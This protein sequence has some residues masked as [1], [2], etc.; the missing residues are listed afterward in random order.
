M[1]YFKQCL[2]FDRQLTKL[3][4]MYQISK[5]LIFLQI[6]FDYKKNAF[7]VFLFGQKLR[8]R[9]GNKLTQSPK[10]TL[11]SK[12]K[13]SVLRR[14]YALKITFFFTRYGKQQ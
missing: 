4:D 1:S 5:L 14:F 3:F 7:F 10:K 8:K 2:I 9:E 6:L 13:I 11:N 12:L